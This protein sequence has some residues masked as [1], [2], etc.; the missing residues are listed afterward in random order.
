[1]LQSHGGVLIFW[2]KNSK[3]HVN[4]GLSNAKDEPA[5]VENFDGCTLL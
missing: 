4:V 1:M 3:S 5:L 2:H